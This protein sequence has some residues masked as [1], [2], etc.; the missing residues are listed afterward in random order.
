MGAPRNLRCN[1][2]MVTAL[3]G[4]LAETGDV[5]AI[6][7][8]RRA[9]AEEA[10]GAQRAGSWIPEPVLDTIFRGE[11]ESGNLARRVGYA[12]T[13]SERIGFMLYTGGVATVEKAY[14][15]CDSLLAREQSGG[16]FESLEISGGKARIAYHPE[17]TAEHQPG[18]D[19][20]ASFCNLRKGM[21]EAI[22]L[23]FGLLPAAV[24]ESQCVGK[25]ASHCCFEVSWSV[26]SK[27]GLVMGAG[28]GILAGVGTS[29]GLIPEVAIPIQLVLGAVI[30]TLC[31][32]AGHAWDLAKQ[33]EVVAGARR[34]HLAL[35]DQADRSLAEKMDELAK[36]GANIESVQNAGGEELRRVLEERRLE[37]E[38]GASEASSRQDEHRE[39]RV[40]AAKEIYHALGPL[41]RGLDAIHRVL[42]E[43]Q[44]TG[45]DS[46]K[47]DKDTA[48]RTLSLCVDEALR[49]QSVGAE[50]AR[51]EQEGTAKHRAV[52]LAEVVTRAADSVR[53]QLG[54][55]RELVLELESELPIVRCEPFQMEQVAYQ[56]IKNA[57]QACDVDGWVRIGLRSTPGG[58]EMEIADN[59]VGIPE[60]ILDDVFDPFSSES[61][62]GSGRGLGLSICYRI[63]V[64]HG[65]EMRVASD[66]GGGTRVTVVLPPDLVAGHSAESESARE[67]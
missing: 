36:I 62:A 43:G 52:S 58:V 13:R 49:I 22:P 47:R 11:G 51:G 30:A 63:V 60:E 56:L 26:G 33:L 46:D 10:P 66:E 34:G 27:R 12:L 2:R 57:S 40:R 53:P 7:R 59:G 20:N 61:D 65:G 44:T 9:L 25:G 8:V 6:N 50:L 28:A 32:L 15:R 64:E 39:C 29:L 38:D 37:G 21:L 67:A 24:V 16:R 17:R 35:L 54:D 41:Q 4:V 23:C 31:G 3:L 14:R 1:S 5:A 19:W 55:G 45:S 18:G 48:L 42:R